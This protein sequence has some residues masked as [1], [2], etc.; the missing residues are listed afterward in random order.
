MGE[1]VRSHRTDGQMPRRARQPQAQDVRR[2]H[3]AG[4]PRAREDTRG[5]WIAR[6]RGL[7]SPSLIVCTVKEMKR[8]L[9]V[10]KDRLLRRRASGSSD[11]GSDKGTLVDVALDEVTYDKVSDSSVSLPRAVPRS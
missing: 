4:P 8:D 5:R 6:P 10:I 1:G 2:V 11:S 9:A 7:V 3:S